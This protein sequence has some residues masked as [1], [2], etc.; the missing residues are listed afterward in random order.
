MALSG[1]VYDFIRFQTTRIVALPKL[2]GYAHN[3]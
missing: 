1:F 3:E 2:K